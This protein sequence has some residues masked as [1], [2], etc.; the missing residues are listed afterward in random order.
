[1][2]TMRR[3]VGAGCTLLSIAGCSS[4]V[5][6]KD[7]WHYPD[8]AHK[9]SSENTVSGLVYML[10]ERLVQLTVQRKPIPSDLN[11]KLAKANADV[12]AKKD[13]LAKAV[14]TLTEAAAL[15]EQLPKTPAQ[16]DLMPDLIKKAQAAVVTA[17]AEKTRAC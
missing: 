3:L 11:D 7:P 2:A 1:M 9:A 6:P 15:L 14:A 13:A 12:Q 17:T 4:L 5:S 10:P 8:K 16:P